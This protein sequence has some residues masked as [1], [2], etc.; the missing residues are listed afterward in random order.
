MILDETRCCC[1]LVGQDAA[2]AILSDEL[3]YCYCCYLVGPDV[4]AAAA[5]LLDAIGAA[6]AFLNDEVDASTIWCISQSVQLHLLFSQWSVINTIN[7]IN[8]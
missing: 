5:I 4:A 2:A 8:T 3:R 7:H 1:Y 6:A